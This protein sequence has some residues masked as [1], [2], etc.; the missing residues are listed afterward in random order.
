M[1]AMIQLL[2]GNP[3]RAERDSIV[4]YRRGASTLASISRKGEGMAL[5]RDERRQEKNKN[6]K[7]TPTPTTKAAGNSNELERTLI[8]QGYTT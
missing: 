1:P 2:V 6:K 5:K 7:T 4:G 8:F 3:R